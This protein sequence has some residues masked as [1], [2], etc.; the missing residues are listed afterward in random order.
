MEN[1]FFCPFH[2]LSCAVVWVEELVLLIHLTRIFV[3][4]CGYFWLP[5]DATLPAVCDG[6]L[7]VAM[8]RWQ[9]VYHLGAVVLGGVN[10]SVTTQGSRWTWGR[11][12]IMQCKWNPPVLFDCATGQGALFQQEEVQS[13][14]AVPIV[15]VDLIALVQKRS[16]QKQHHLFTGTQVRVANIGS[17]KNWLHLVNRS[18]RAVY[19]L[20]R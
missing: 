18:S 12:H 19:T 3:V 6:C 4:L 10:L 5:G 15:S 16:Y 8:H 9:Q 17:L 14:A 1:S 7:F 2:W 20:K 13:E 11:C